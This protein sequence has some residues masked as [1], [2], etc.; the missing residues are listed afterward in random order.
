MPFRNIL[1]DN[2]MELG[3]VSEEDDYGIWQCVHRQK[4][5]SFMKFW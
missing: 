1:L 4:H 5:K 3:S 2:V